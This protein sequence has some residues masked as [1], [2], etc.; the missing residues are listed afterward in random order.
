MSGWKKHGRAGSRP[1]QGR[2]PPV[3]A[4]PPSECTC[5]ASSSP[6]PSSREHHPARSA[7]AAPRRRSPATSGGDR[8]RRPGGL[9]RRDRPGATRHSHCAARSRRLGV[10]GQP[11]HL[12]LAAQPGD[13]RAARRARR[14]SQDRA[15]VDRRAQLLSRRRSAALPD[16]AGRQPEAPADGQ[17]GAVP[18]RTDPARSLP[19]DARADRHPMGHAR[20][21]AA[22]PRRRRQRSR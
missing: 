4:N 21:R 7:A 16:A 12:H 19:R 10:R 11:R 20:D 1:R 6:I 8:R 14:L 5:R 9:L 17:P 13:H 3:N 2:R 18:H 22:A 15:A